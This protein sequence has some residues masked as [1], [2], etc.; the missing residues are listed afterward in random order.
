MRTLHTLLALLV[1]ALAFQSC[2]KDNNNNNNDVPE[3]FT[4]LRVDK[5][6]NFESFHNVQ[7][8]IQLTNSRIAGGEIIQIFDGHPNQGGKL[9]LTGTAN[10][11]GMFTL[12]LRIASRLEEVYVAR[13]NAYENNE[14]VAVPV[15]G[16][17]ISFSFA[18]KDLEQKVVDPFCDCDADDILPNN[19]NANLTIPQ[20][21]TR[22]VAAGNHATIKDLTIRT[23][24]IL[25][26]CGTA[27]VNKYRFDSREGTILI[28]PSGNLTLPKFDL[29]FT[30]QN[31]GNINY[32]GNGTSNFDGLLE[33]WG[34][35]T[36]TLKMV[37]RGDI[38]NNGTFT[39]NKD[40]E[41]VATGSIINNCKFLLTS[42]D[43]FKQNGSLINNGYLYVDGEAEF[44]GN[45][46]NRTELGQG[47]L[48]EADEFKINGE[49][50][51]PESGYAQIKAND[52]GRVNS[53][54]DLTNLDLCADDAEYSNNADYTNVT[55]CE[56]SVPVPDCGTFAAPE[57]TSSLQIGGLAGET[58]TPYQITATGTEPITYSVSSL[59][60]GLSF[61]ANTA[62]IS[63]TPTTAGTYNVTLTASNTFGQDVET[64]VIQITQPV[65]PPV[66]TSVLTKQATVDEPLSYTLTASGT[67][68]ITLNATNL[69]AGL[70]FNSE[71][72]KITGS[73]SAAGVYNIT[74]SASNAGGTTTETLVLTVGTPPEITNELTASGTA[75][76]QFSTFTVTA[77]G[78]PDI[79]IEVSNL[80]QNLSFNPTTN[81][82]NGTPTFAGEYSVLITAT[83]DFGNDV[84]TLVITIAEGLQAPEIT[85]ALTASG[86]VDFPF[87]Y[88][89]EATGSQTMTF[90]AVNLPS[91]LTISG[92]TI[93]GVP[94]T[95]GTYNVTISATNAAG[96]DS[97]T[98]VITITEGTAND[99]DGD[100][101][102]DDMDAYPTDPERAFNSFYPNEV[103]FVSVAFEDLWPAYGDYDFNDFVINLNYKTVTNA[104]N[105]VVDVI[106]KY[107]IMADGASLDNGFGLVFDALPETVESVTGYIK[108]GNAV[109]LD[110][111]GFE[112]GHTNET[113]V[114]LVDNI[115]PIM[116]GGMANTI[117]G[118][119]YVQT[120]VNTVTVNFSD[121][122]QNIGTPPYNPFIFVDQ[123][124]SHEVH[125]KNQ[126]PTEFVDEE[127]FG[128][129]NDASDPGS[130]NYYLS[131]SGLPWAIE[132][133]IN[134]EYPVEAADILTAH[135]KFA[136]WAQ[137]SGVD[138][139]DWYMN[140]TGY[141]NDENIYVVPQ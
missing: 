90:S 94:T 35:V 25:K 3:A 32:S 77:T 130:N 91:G 96:T 55:F 95:A 105:L 115:N 87:S 119:K 17:T 125:L 111:K 43:D 83:N 64:L 79:T 23:G 4:D 28:S 12:P 1:F 112:A 59:P 45:G 34:T 122:Q 38:I 51:G 69:P 141:R 13:L 29:N 8:A 102:A 123:V 56:I 98:L 127:L 86:A 9:I 100:G 72:A 60:A 71:T 85:S 57:I 118:G 36:L 137:S 103:D 106:V 48:I 78:T 46:N 47:S 131:P 117:P 136:A 139:P 93:I 114:I 39:T 44:T 134:F 19:F 53:S 27:S 109:M 63:G 22:C 107:Q 138:F 132:T 31:Y 21:E 135:L 61:N 124:R 82:I 88:T 120:T 75:G 14:Y 7:T 11:Q 41:L 6:F 49:I 101:I 104:Q 52:E 108:L 73:P 2:R 129:N 24:A 40:F 66:I 116:E 10:D 89:I 42:D 121:P 113:V 37:S 5:A 133:P 126:R 81:Q 92:N 58:I 84:K 15:S 99:T 128:T 54:A 33:N 62:T 65:D 68:P 97:K 76:V 140:K 74:L 50:V 26:I 67:G 110:P 80:P 70:V 16:N 18:N 20:G 30:V